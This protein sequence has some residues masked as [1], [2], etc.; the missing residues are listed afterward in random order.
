MKAAKRPIQG[1]DRIF[2][3]T[4]GDAGGGISQGMLQRMGP[5]K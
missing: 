3:G 2:Q 1:V 5:P 4:K